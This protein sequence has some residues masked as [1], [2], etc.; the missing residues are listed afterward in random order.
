MTIGVLTFYDEMNFG[1]NLQGIS[2]Y[3]NLKKRGHRPVFIN[4]RA[5]SSLQRINKIR[6]KAQFV[7]HHQ[8]VSSIIENQ[9]NVCST[10]DDLMHEVEHWGI[11]AIIIGSD[12]VLQHHPLICRIKKGRRKPFYIEN[13]VDECLFPNLF[14]GVG[15][16]DKIPTAMMSVSSQNS[17]FG[18][19]L[20]FTK[21]NMK[22]A[23][24]WIKYISVRDTWTQRMIE[25]ITGNSCPVTPDPV[26]AFN[27]NAGELVKSK[28][29]VISKYEIPENYILVSLH[30]QSLPLSV[31]D[32]LKIEF[33]KHNISCV[34][35]TM[36]SGINFCH[37]FDYEINPPLSPIDWY[38][39]IKYANAYI[40]SN[41]HPIVV[42]LHNA[43]P[44]V[45]IDNWGRTDFFNRKINDGSSK[46]KHIMK[47]F[48]VDGNHRMINK[49]TCNISAEEI[50]DLIYSFPKEDVKA[51]SKVM[52]ER[53]DRMMEEIIESLNN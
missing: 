48:H 21:R 47:E 42:S 8:F 52:S 11:E 9:T 28:E 25:S 24:S 26:F 31:L 23:L 39:L 32:D 35:L 41:M 45:S 44:C 2:T 50:I 13:Y 3:L 33:G 5:N 16:A 46:V 14:W 40:G 27:N 30:S 15:Y 18:S 29:Y 34:A 1:A 38:S 43:V 49:G 7:A 37:N 12:A 17:E 51:H 53:Y 19:F 10:L 36:P 4:Y 22:D 6:T 20:S